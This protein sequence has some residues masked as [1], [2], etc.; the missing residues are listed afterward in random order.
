ML[1]LETIEKVKQSLVKAKVIL[2]PELEPKVFIRTS[3]VVVIDNFLNEDLLD[4]LL[5]FLGNI[6]LSLPVTEGGLIPSW[7]NMKDGLPLKGRMDF[8]FSA[9]PKNQE[10]EEKKDDEPKSENI[11]ESYTSPIM[12]RIA[13]RI[14]EEAENW[15]NVIGKMKK[16]W[17]K[18]TIEHFVYQTG[19]GKTFDTSDYVNYFPSYEFCLSDKW[20]INWGGTILANLDV[21]ETEPRSRL[22]VNNGFKDPSS[23]IWIYPK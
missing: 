3:D 16:D 17:K 22:E 2:D 1:A 4:S 15:E 8:E 6:P 7:F 13:N 11:D 14:N 10:K 20:D 19:A 21:V 23:G 9:N 5:I 12:V 18:F